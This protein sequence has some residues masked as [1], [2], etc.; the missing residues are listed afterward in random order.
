MRLTTATFTLAA[1]AMILAASPA[2]AVDFH[3]Y[4][5]TGIGGTTAGGKQQCFA[6]PDADYKFRLGNECETYAE[7]EF[8]ETIYKD[9]NGIEF[10]WDTMLHYKTV[11]AQDA[12]NLSGG[13]NEIALRQAWVGATVPQLGGALVWVGKRYFM[14]QDVHMIDYFYWDVSGPGAG[15]EGLD[16]K[17]GKL[18]VSVFNNR[19]GDRQMWRPELRL[20]DVD[21]G[22]GKLA[23]GYSAYVD[24]SPDS[25]APTALAAKAVFDARET[26]SHWLN[27]QWSVVLL[28]GRNN[29]TVQWGNGSASG[30]QSYPNWDGSSKSTQFRLVEDLVINPSDSWTLGASATYADYELRYNMEATNAGAAWNSGSQW[31]LGARPIYHINDVF[32][33]A[34]EVGYNSV[35]PNEGNT[36]ARTMLKAT[37]AFLIHPPAGLGGAYF[38]RPELRFFVSYASWNDAA[39]AAGAF[40]Q[41][42]CAATGAAAGSVFSCDSNGLTIGAQAE[43][44]W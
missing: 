2:A 20:Y 8:A 22:L 44:W 18:A 41:G 37:P 30:L 5:R 1:M 27:A 11:Q 32:S 9:K 28:G 35:T 7:A 13:G 12:E 43:A 21:I 17:I 39:Q 31:G 42:S 16:V 33:V 19:N 34:L 3:G 38:T 10:K 23:F 26:F 4:A 24:S 36:D 6:A 40:G 14:R 29:F 25:S 15:V